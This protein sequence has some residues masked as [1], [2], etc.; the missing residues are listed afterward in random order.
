RN[1]DREH[2]EQAVFPDVT[3]P[4]DEATKETIYSSYRKGDAVELLAKRFN[5]TRTSV[6]RVI[7]EVRAQRLLD[8]PLEYVSHPSFEDP[9]NDAA[10]LAPMPEAGEYEARRRAMKAPKD[11]GAELAPLYEMPLLNKEQEAHLFR[12]MN[13]LKFKASKLRDQFRKDGAPD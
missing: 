10:I 6:Y 13:Y 9:A 1:F 7:N 5:R 8:L 11:V 3:G 2:P 4:L 12:Q